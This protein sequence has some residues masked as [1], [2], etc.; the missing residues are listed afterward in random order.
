MKNRI[1]VQLHSAT[2]FVPLFTVQKGVY[3]LLIRLEKDCSL[4]VGRLGIFRFPKG[5]YV[6]TGSAQNNMDKRIARHLTQRKKMHWHIDYLL[7][8]AEIIKVVKYTGL[9]RDEC[10]INKEIGKHPDAK[11]IVRG[12]GSSDCRCRTHLYSFLSKRCIENVLQNLSPFHKN[13]RI[14]NL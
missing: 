12:F 7:K 14:I 13:E 3:N 8:V 4:K 10:R 5:Y 1:S 9:K 11:I 2:G 6:Y